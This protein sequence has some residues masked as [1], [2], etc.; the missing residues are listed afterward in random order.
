M[1]KTCQVILKI[2][3]IVCNAVFILFNCVDFPFFRFIQ[4]RTTADVFDL[5]QLGDDTKNTIPQMAIDFWYVLAL[6]I[7][8]ILLLWIFY[9]K[10]KNWNSKTKPRFSNW[11]LF[12]GIS[13]M[14]VIISR[15]G[16]QLKPLRTIDATDHTSPRN[17]PL[18]LNTT[19]TLLK[20]WG[21]VKVEEIKYFENGNEKKYFSSAKKY[22][23]SQPFRPFNVV[24][25]VLESFSKEYIGGLNNGE[26]YTPFL[27]S[28]MKE[29]LTFTNA[30]ANSKKSIEGIPA[31]VSSIPALMTEPFITSVYNGNKVNS[32][33]SCLKTKNYTTAFFHGGNNGTMGF[34]NF[35]KAAGFDSYVG[36][37]E[38]G[39]KDYDGNWGVFDHKFYSFF[40]DRMNRMPG[41]FMT[42]FFSISS[43]HPYRI[44]A[45]LEGKFK[46]GTLPIHESIMYADYALKTF[47]EKAKQQ[48]WFDNTLF[49][50]TSDHTGPAAKPEYQTRLG[51]FKVPVI[52]YMHHAKWNKFDSTVTQQCDIMPSV[53]DFLHY[54]GSF[55]A[56]GNSVFDSTAKHFAVNYLNDSYQ[57][58]SNNYLIEF[59]GE[60]PD[61][62]FDFVNDP[63]LGKN[64]F[65]D[66]SLLPNEL[67]T[68]K[69]YIQQFNEAMIR[70]KLSE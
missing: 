16:I 8:F 49:V 47:F 14:L 1:T 54:D 33:A 46:K 62:I 28:L 56:F 20:T 59:D 41:P 10:V 53:L 50:I 43:H 13:V 27:D 66:G 6:W 15:G 61:G 60:R 11:F 48:S 36:R 35:S 42:C 55:V 52:Y 51:I 64:Y 31:V 44:P 34:D 23:S 18:V 68:L 26:G 19:F 39:D 21:K 22:K 63:L 25:I 17:A 57:H 67:N 40:I 29:S 7:G 5:L 32:I 45:G 69:S 4:K 30:F 2:L 65:I 3:F 12:L 38:Y 58:V 37:K 24:I 70:N 9:P